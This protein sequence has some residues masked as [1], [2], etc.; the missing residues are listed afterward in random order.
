MKKIVSIITAVSLAAAVSAPA[1]FADSGSVKVALN[2]SYVSFDGNSGKPFISEEN[3]TLVP[4]RSTAE[5]YG[6]TVTWDQAAYRATVNYEG[7]EVVVPINEYYVT[8][9]G[10]Q[11]N[12]D[13]CARIKNDRTYLPIRQVMEAVGAQ[14][15]WDQTNRTVIIENPR[16][17]K[18]MLKVLENSLTEKG[19]ADSL[20]GRVAELPK[21]ETD[22]T[23]ETGTKQILAYKDGQDAVYIYRT[24][25]TEN[26]SYSLAAAVT[27]PYYSS[28][29]LWMQY[30]N[31]DTVRELEYDV[32]KSKS[33]DAAGYKLIRGSMP[34]SSNYDVAQLI[35]QVEAMLRGLQKYSDAEL[36]G[37][38]ISGLGFV[39]PEQEES[40]ESG[41]AE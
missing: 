26:G 7:T 40:A 28:M 19:Q 18:N 14:V 2:G 32:D 3:R 13:T 20:R 21:D 39:L 5:A 38:N 24:Y 27:E 25:A 11:R 12:S 30:R 37:M 17:Y 29:T 36:E 4:L 23:D 15:E 6:C 8:V 1:A 22:E 34:E 9:N 16:D 31:G 10:E 35:P 33:G 41:S